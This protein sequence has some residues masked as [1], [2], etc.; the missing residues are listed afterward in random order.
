[1]LGPSTIHPKRE[2]LLAVFMSYMW[3]HV[4]QKIELH[5]PMIKP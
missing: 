1:M 5:V 2:H 4:D 3:F